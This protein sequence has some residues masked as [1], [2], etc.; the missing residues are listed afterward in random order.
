M[1]KN[2]LSELVHLSDRALINKLRLSVDEARAI[3]QD[4]RQIIL[5]T[6]ALLRRAERLRK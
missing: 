6:Y 4:T 5:E 2:H 1:P 3:S